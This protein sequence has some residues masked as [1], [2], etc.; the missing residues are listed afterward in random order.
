MS[1]IYI[2]GL[3]GN[4]VT[5]GKEWQEQRRFS[6]K[7]L[8]NFGFGK[9]SMESIMHEEVINFAEQLRKESENG[10]VDLA[11]KF[12]VMVINVLWRIIGKVCGAGWTS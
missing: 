6:F 12:N 8:K 7:T 4:V 5:E 1:D 11:N 9:S 2:H 3:H 10:R